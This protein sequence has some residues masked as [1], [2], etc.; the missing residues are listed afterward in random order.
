MLVR[1]ERHSVLLTEG[2]VLSL[3]YFSLLVQ[4][5][6]AGVRKRVDNRVEEKERAH[7]G[8]RPRNLIAPTIDPRQ[9]VRRGLQSRCSDRPVGLHD[10]TC[11]S[12]IEIDDPGPELVRELAHSD[13]KA[14]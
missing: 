10:T 13:L 9:C 14:T 2:A 4:G 3:Y 5:S 1:P 7:G 11:A 8:R 12:A 6:A